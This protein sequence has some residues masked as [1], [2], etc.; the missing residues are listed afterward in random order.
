MKSKDLG[1]KQRKRMAT[2]VFMLLVA[3][4]CRLVLLPHL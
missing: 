1:T 3:A 2:L 4:L